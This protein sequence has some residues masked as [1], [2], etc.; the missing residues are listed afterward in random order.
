MFITLNLTLQL[1]FSALT[2]CAS[3]G[4]DG[5]AG[6]WC[7]VKQVFVELSI[8]CQEMYRVSILSNMAQLITW[9]VFLVVFP[10]IAKKL[11]ELLTKNNPKYLLG[12]GKDN[13]PAV[14]QTCEKT[15]ESVLLDQKLETA[16][17]AV[18]VQKLD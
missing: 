7:G 9:G 11:Q 18:P 4:Y 6:M 8:G 10:T 16:E 2:G 13:V 17:S 1:L 3:G 12:I 5:I 15:G 14:A